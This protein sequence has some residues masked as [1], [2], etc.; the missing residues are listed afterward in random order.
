MD[1]YNYS[2]YDE[3][4]EE[5]QP[6]VRCPGKEITGMILGIASTVWGILSL[7]FCWMPIEGLIIDIVYALFVLGFSIATFILNAKVRK[8]ATVVTKKIT[9]GVIMAIIGLVITAIAIVLAV[10]LSVAAFEMCS[11]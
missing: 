3:P 9:F 4:V 7:I 2:Y 1:E 5:Y 8:E 10:I 11:Y 6:E